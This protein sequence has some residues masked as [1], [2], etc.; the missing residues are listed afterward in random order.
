LNAV[1]VTTT[2]IEG[3]EEVELSLG[4]EGVSLLLGDFHAPTDCLGPTL[5]GFSARFAVGPP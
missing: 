5:V 2:V 1:A 3:A 4:L